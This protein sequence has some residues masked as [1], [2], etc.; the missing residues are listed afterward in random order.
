MKHSFLLL[1]SPILIYGSTV[2]GQ[3]LFNDR[4]GGQVQ[5][6]KASQRNKKE[7]NLVTDFELVKDI[8][9]VSSSDPG[10]SRFNNPPSFAVNNGV[11]YFA[12]EDG[13]HG[14]ELWRSDGSS[15]GTYLVKD[16]NPGEAAS[17]P[18]EIAAGNNKVF[19]SAF[20]SVYGQELWVSDGTPEGTK[21]LLDAKPGPGGSWPGQIVA[22]GKNIFFLTSPETSYYAYR[23]FPYGYQV[24]KTEG[25]ERTTLLLL[26]LTDETNLFILQCTKVND[27]LFF[28]VITS[29]TFE[30]E[31]WRSDGTKEGT[32]PVKKFPSN[33]F[34]LMHFT[35]Y[36][37]KLYFSANDGTGRQLWMSDG[38][39]EGTVPAPGNNGIGL[40]EYYH[41]KARIPFQQ[42]NNSLLMFGYSNSDGS[43][44]YK[45]DATSNRG[46]E[47]VK[48]LLPASAHPAAVQSEI[49]FVNEV[50]YFNLQS[51][52][53]NGEELWRSDGTAANTKLIKRFE[54][55]YSNFYEPYAHNGKIYFTKEDNLYGREPWLSDGTAEGTSLLKDIYKGPSVSSPSFFTTIN[56]KLIFSAR[57]ETGSELWTTN[58]TEAGTRIL[59]DINTHSTAGMFYSYGGSDAMATLNKEL[60]FVADDGQPGKRL[61]KSDGST[62]G[63]SVLK[64]LTSAPRLL[65][66]RNDFVYFVT[67]YYDSTVLVN[68][69]YRTNG[70]KNGTTKLL[71][72]RQWKY[73]IFTY[74]VSQDGTVYYK[75]RKDWESAYELWRTDGTLQGTYLLMTNVSPETNVAVAGNTAYFVAGK[76][77]SGYELWNTDGTVEGTKMIKDIFPGSGGSN[78]YNLFTYKREIYFGA[79]DPL[80]DSSFWKTDGT[81]AGT[82]KLRNITL[83]TQPFCIS[84]DILY[85]KANEKTAIPAQGTQLWKTNGT[86]DG[87]KIV[88]TINAGHDVN[89]SNLTDVDGILFF[90]AD[91]GVHGVELWASDGSDSG[92]RMVK[93]INPPGS[94]HDFSC[95]TSAEGRLFFLRDGSLDNS[96]LWS[97]DGTD[98]NTRLVD[99]EGLDKI[100]SMYQLAA[101]KKKL[102]LI[103]NSYQYGIELYATSIKEKSHPL[104]EN[105]F[106][107]IPELQTEEAFAIRVFPNPAKNAATLEINGNVINVSVTITDLTGKIVWKRIYNNERQIKLPIEKWS[108]GLYTVTVNNHCEVKTIK[109]VKF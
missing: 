102:F 82:F 18:M 51:Y 42:I 78:P 35:T 64:D 91:D 45:Y 19:F 22:A 75:V 23:F 71:E 24:W 6:E 47:L 83:S 92:T 55:G 20:T 10:N 7:K 14:R 29:Y 104:H 9:L 1:L 76:D 44:L 68:N 40:T 84:N 63:T 5:Y 97:S 99:D 8:N 50:V 107:T 70:K 28:T 103:G 69:I 77:A 59:K 95:F 100:T 57:N 108:T 49:V 79:R 62:S 26:D 61:Y 109:L 56:G 11:S 67:S 66:S 32:F 21:I 38:T 31:L 74:E 36:N 90:T 12:A 87:T 81:S 13:I 101:V 80:S 60:I 46:M 88:K 33:F 2:Q 85:F 27:L 54:A 39:G 98:G 58:G 106:R 89:A 53:G 25:T 43:G 37:N 72:T 52:A 30:V 105:E 15:G 86:S 93:D 65:L 34:G 96:E 4:Q 41:S 17:N 94:K 3:I 16:L 48:T 73:E